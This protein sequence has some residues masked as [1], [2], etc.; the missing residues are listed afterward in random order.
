MKTIVSMERWLSCYWAWLRLPARLLC[1]LIPWRASQ[2]SAASA[3][4]RAGAA[5][6][7]LDHQQPGAGPARCRRQDRRR[8]VRHDE[9]GTAPSTLWRRTRPARARRQLDER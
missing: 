2:P 3:T 1:G 7:L 8:L 6:R 4:P 5:R 9:A